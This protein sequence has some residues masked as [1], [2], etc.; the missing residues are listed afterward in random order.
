MNINYQRWLLVALLL[1]LPCGCLQ[2]DV[3]VEMEEDGG[4]T[5]TERVRFSA[6]LLDLDKDTP[7]D[8]QV[9]RL[10]TKEAVQERTKIMGKGVRLVSHQ[11]TDLPG[12]ARQSLAVY[13]VPDLEDLRLLN[14]YLIQAPANRLMRFQLTPIYRFVHS[15]HR[16]GDVMLYLVPAETPKRRPRREDAPPP[17]EPTPAQLQTIRDLQPAFA[18]MLEDFHIK[19]RLIATKPISLGY[20][21]DRKASTKVINLI[22]FTHQD[23]DAFGSPFVENEELM[24]TLLRWRMDADVLTEHTKGFAN[25]LTVPVFRGKEPYAVGRFRIKPT[26]HLFQKFYAGRPKSQGGDVEDKRDD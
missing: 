20:V 10:L 25:N 1:V 11:A 21:R 24:L 12:G 7:A 9:A 17:P 3:T 5:I 22:S 6:A 15:F 23:L 14:P 2:I 18:D 13:H 16:V 26:K 19:L 8:Q 4:A